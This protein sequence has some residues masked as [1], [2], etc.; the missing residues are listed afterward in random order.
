MR[1]SSLFRD[2][3]FTDFIKKSFQYDNTSLSFSLWSPDVQTLPS[4]ACSN[5]RGFYISWIQRQHREFFAPREILNSISM[6]KQFHAEFNA[7]RR[8]VHLPR[9]FV[10]RIC[11]T[12]F[13]AL[14]IFLLLNAGRNA[15]ILQTVVQLCACVCVYLEFH[16]SYFNLSLSLS[17]SLCVETE[18]GSCFDLNGPFS[19]P[20]C[21]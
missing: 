16:N 2:K 12:L 17:H 5:W 20:F 11:C 15:K 9:S 8:K 21:L 6:L 1:R 19:W 13:T 3:I 4:V 18:S 7:N 14:V 10:L